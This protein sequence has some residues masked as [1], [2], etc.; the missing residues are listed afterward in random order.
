MGNR[1]AVKIFIKL[2]NEEKHFHYSLRF[3][4]KKISAGSNNNGKTQLTR[5]FFEILIP[6]VFFIRHM[7]A[8]HDSISSEMLLNIKF[9]PHLLTYIWFLFR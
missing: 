4:R 8:A 1:L 7:I 6:Q 3:F 5:F 2:T 9:S